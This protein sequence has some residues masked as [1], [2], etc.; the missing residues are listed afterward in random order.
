MRVARAVA[1]GSLALAALTVAPP[2][3]VIGQGALVAVARAAESE[4]TLKLGLDLPLSGIDGASAIPA[5]NA[6]VLAVDAANRRGF[7][8]GSESSSTISTTRC[9]ASTIRRK[10]LKTSKR[11]SPIPTSSRWSAR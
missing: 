11:S 3:A 2:A 6:V 7:P 4:R 8:H 5:R 1:V 10:A 9:K